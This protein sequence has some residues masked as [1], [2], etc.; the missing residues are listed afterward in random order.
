VHGG[1]WIR[2]EYWHWSADAQFLA[3]RG[4]AVIE[5]EFRGST[6]YGARHFRAG[7]KQWGRAMQDDVDDALD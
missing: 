3:S 4:Y 7:W 5:P 6:G 1:P 2:G